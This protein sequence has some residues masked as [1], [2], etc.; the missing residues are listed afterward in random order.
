MHK[1]TQNIY[2]LLAEQLIEEV[3]TSDYYS[4]VIELT[5][6]DTVYRLAV[7]LVIYHERASFSSDEGSPII[8]VV[9]VW[10]EL[11]TITSTGYQ[12]NDFDFNTLRK[13]IKQC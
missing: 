5:N 1:I 3:L 10:W 2:I 9:D 6:D 11:H 13:I 7:S 8:D 4:G 12:L